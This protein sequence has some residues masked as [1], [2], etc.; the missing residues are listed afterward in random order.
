MN[1]NEIKVKSSLKY[2]F[3]G[4][5]KY[6]VSPLSLK[7]MFSILKSPKTGEPSIFFGFMNGDNKIRKCKV[8]FVRTDKECIQNT[9]K[10]DNYDSA[11]VIYI[12]INNLSGTRFPSKISE[13]IKGIC[14]IEAVRQAKLNQIKKLKEELQY[15]DTTYNKLYSEASTIAEKEIKKDEKQ[16]TEKEYLDELSKCILNNWYVE[17]MDKYPTS[18]QFS[19]DIASRISFNNLPY[20]FF[21]SRHYNGE[22]Y[23]EYSGDYSQMTDK[24]V[25]YSEKFLKHRGT[26]FSRSQLSISLEKLVAYNKISKNNKFKNFK[27]IFSATFEPSGKND[28]TADIVY[29]IYFEFKKLDKKTFEEIQNFVKNNNMK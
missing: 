10:F 4:S 28:C 7:G 18:I 15:D 19:N 22:C 25:H 1:L 24:V 21:G 5:Q 6:N 9:S 26:D 29:N 17:R 3:K 2:E 20:G 23:I 16:Y 27:L 8:F 13:H 14:D 12:N 11:I